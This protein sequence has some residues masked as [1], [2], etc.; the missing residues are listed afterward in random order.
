MPKAIVVHQLGGLEVLKCEDVESL[1]LGESEVRVGVHS[2]SANFVDILMA[3]GK[4]QHKPELPYIAGLEMAG[5]I[6]EVGEGVTSVRVGD[7]VTG[8]AMPGC[9][10]EEMILHERAVSPKPDVMT[11][12]EA[13]GYRTGASTGYVALYRRAN[14]QPGE[15]LLVQ[16]AAGGMG[17]A[18]VQIGKLLGAKVIGTVGSDSKFEAVRQAGADHVINYSDGFREQVLEIT[19]KRGADVIYDPV[20]GDVFD[21]ST[22][23]IAFGGRILIIGFASGRIPTVGVNIPLIKGFSVVGVRAGEFG[24]RNPELAAENAVQL[25]EWA[26]AGKITPHVSHFFRL[27]D[28]GAALQVLVDRKAIGRVVIETDRGRA[29]RLGSQESV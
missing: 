16:G 11:F 15:T 2:A 20:G 7:Q 6:V 27:E 26:E 22:R 19:S 23:C 5:E 3:A 4:Y 17:L 8:G 13:C 29:A 24:R 12:A 10:T 21:E 25:K 28:A 14:I 9:F 18:A 1:P